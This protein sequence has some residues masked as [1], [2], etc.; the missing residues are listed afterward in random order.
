MRI[1][2]PSQHMTTTPA[3]GRR[4]EIANFSGIIR[5]CKR[6]TKITFLAVLSPKWILRVRKI[7]FV[8]CS[9]GRTLGFWPNKMS[10][11][12]PQKRPH[13]MVAG[14]Q[15]AH[16]SMVD[17]YKIPH[18]IPAPKR[19]KR[20][21]RRRTPRRSSRARRAR[22]RTPPRTSPRTLHR[23][24]PRNRLHPHLRTSPRYHH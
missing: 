8:Y 7:Y 16:L 19:A 3:I 17:C 20:P 12:V 15:T 11:P 21:G 9:N 6:G 10:G 22:P 1:V 14:D 18:K 24:S 13:S 4:W 23:R 5:F 2:Q